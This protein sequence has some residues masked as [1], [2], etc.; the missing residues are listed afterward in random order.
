M[1][2][3]FA[4]V[5]CRQLPISQFENISY[6]NSSLL[7]W[8]R[9]NNQCLHSIDSNVTTEKKRKWISASLLIG[10]GFLSYRSENSFVPNEGTVKYDSRTGITAGGE[11][12]LILPFNN[13]KWSV[14]A[15]GSTLSY[16]SSGYDGAGN[17][18]SIDY[19]TINLL[20]GIRYY[21][22][23]D[24]KWKALFDAGL[25][26]DIKQSKFSPA[27]GI[28]ISY[29]RFS[30]EFRYFAQRGLYDYYIVFGEK[31][32]FTNMFLAFKYRLFQL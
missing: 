5:N 18:K 32:H 2:Q 30:F 20:L 26:K 14:V 6:S 7:R 21:G 22:F 23:F 25:A 19:N 28:G 31:Q 13:N 3:L 15:E 10:A 24:D 27:L 4:N 12:E 1:N 29:T 17:N 9:Q 16:N 11:V 8:F